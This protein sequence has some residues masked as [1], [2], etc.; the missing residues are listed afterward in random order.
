[1]FGLDVLKGSE[2]YNAVIR[3]IAP[4]P[5]GQAPTKTDPPAKPTGFLLF[6]TDYISLRKSL[7][8]HLTT[9]FLLSCIIAVV[10]ALISNS[11]SNVLASLP[12][13]LVISNCIGL[14]IFLCLTLARFTFM[15]G[16]NGSTTARWV[17]YFGLVAIGAVGGNELAGLLVPLT[18]PQFQFTSGRGA[19][20]AIVCAFIAATIATDIRFNQAAK[21]QHRRDLE[22][23]ERTA[24][25]AQLRALQA[26]I[27]PHFL[28][29]T[30]ANLDALIATDAARARGLLANLIRYLRAALMH[31]RSDNATLQTEME[32]L[33][34]YLAIM[35]QRLPNRLSTQFDCDPD[36]LR[37]GFPAMLVQPLVENAITHGIEPAPQGGK[38]TVSVQRSNEMLLISVDD[39]GVG[40]GKAMHPGTGAGI[41]NIR[42]RLRA[43]FGDAAKLVLEERTPQG[44][45]AG[46]QVPLNLLSEAHG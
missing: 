16:F 40:L 42:A 39:T 2:R 36:C 44:T 12:S 20:V 45:H 30:L 6:A 34:A 5:R 28:F 22:R 9:T 38:I 25:E 19:V 18:D 24:I 43:L 15:R 26:Q 13:N 14:S 17:I 33:K 41:E 3:N 32:L 29:N 8:R 1:M 4:T 10:I 11:F 37:L 35:T 7:P 46:I 23:A 21:A 27:E 31:A